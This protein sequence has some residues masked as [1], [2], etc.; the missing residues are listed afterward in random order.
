MVV[1]A[2]AKTH[3]VVEPIDDFEIALLYVNHKFLIQGLVPLQQSNLG[4]LAIVIFLGRTYT[5]C[6]LVKLKLE[7]LEGRVFLLVLV[8]Q[9]T[10]RCLHILLE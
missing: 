5:R 7:I 4:V 9:I 10:N 6:G 8:F 3:D 1:D 2:I